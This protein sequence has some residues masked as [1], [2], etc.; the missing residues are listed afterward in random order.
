M[1]D[2]TSD[3]RG[4]TGHS[5]CFRPP[6]APSNSMTDFARQVLDALPMTV[7]TTDLDGIITSTNRSWSL[8]ANENGAPTLATEQQVCGSSLW[9]A[10]G[11]PGYRTQL[12]T[13]MEQLRT[14]RVS[15]IAWEFP[16]SSP[17]E[18]RVFLMQITALHDQEHRV[19]GFVFSTVD[20]TPSHQSREVLID[21]GL[22]LSRPLDSERVLGEVAANVRRAIPCDA[23]AVWL[24]HGDEAPS[25]AFASAEASPTVVHGPLRSAAVAAI[26]RG[27]LV[28][29]EHPEGRILAAPMAPGR[30][31]GGAMAL[32]T[33][34]LESRHEQ[35]E[36]QRLLAT[37]AAQA[38]AAIERVHLVRQLG[39]K[40]RL[41]AIGEVATG[42]AHELRNPLFGISSAAQ[43]LR[44]RAREDVVVE[45]NVGRIL[46]EV[47]RLNRMVGSLLDF[48]RPKPVAF[49][50]GDPD[51]VWDEVLE[52]QRALLESRSLTLR[53]LRPATASACSI[54]AEQVAQVFLNLLM[55]AADHAPPG[56]EL[57]LRSSVGAGQWRCDL[58]NGGPAIPPDALARVFEMFF[59][60]KPGGSGIGLAICQRIV[61]EHGGTI[62]M[63]SSPAV[64]TT[65]T[66]TL[67]LVEPAGG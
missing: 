19:N 33:D 50:T 37:I 18:E 13:A 24:Q 31:S 3:P 43:L 29:A 32:L 42:V 60:T 30:L 28:F 14:G 65:V 5:F 49:A 16:C 55:N 11:D 67:P 66:L 61:E 40:H 6:P 27:D 22:A 48:G 59:S 34:R 45:R 35:E 63:T 21:T 44:F 12:R 57:Q 4:A 52:G 62:S 8:F 7:Y 58:T 41:E 10:F 51:T 2:L 1:F 36:A 54:D 26:A 9:A 56:S 15:R 38:G 64:G 39:H 25:L 17:T 46:R 47:E 23:F 20:I 53:R